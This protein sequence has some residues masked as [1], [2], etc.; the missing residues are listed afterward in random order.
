M[1]KGLGK[2]SELPPCLLSLSNQNNLKKKKGSIHCILKT[3]SV[4]NP[5]ACPDCKTIWESICWGRVEAWSSLFQSSLAC[6]TEFPVPW[7]QGEC[8]CRTESMKWW[9]KMRSCK[10]LNGIFS[11]YAV[12]SCLWV[13]EN[14]QANKKTN[15][16][17][18]SWTLAFCFLGWGLWCISLVYWNKWS[19][20]HL[21][22]L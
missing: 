15:K 9:L 10:L 1:C 18:S 20:A 16:K 4:C 7:L 14:D 3:K 5:Q 12:Y 17:K 22:F 11:I 19:R 6:R 8:E 13:G 2:A 21:D